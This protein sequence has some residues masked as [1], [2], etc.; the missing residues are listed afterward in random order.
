MGGIPPGGLIDRLLSR[1]GL[2]GDALL[3]AQGATHCS[4]IGTLTNVV[5]GA[6]RGAFLDGD[7]SALKIF[8]KTK[9]CTT[10]NLSKTSPSYNRNSPDAAFD[11]LPKL[12]ISLSMGDDSKKGAFGLICR[13]NFIHDRYM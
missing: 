10:G 11:Q 4:P 3:S 12:E 2:T 7:Q 9:C 8:P 13:M 6:S 5:S 1:L